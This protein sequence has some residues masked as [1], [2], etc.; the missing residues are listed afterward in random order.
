MQTPSP[1]RADSLCRMD[2]PVNPPIKPM[3]AKPVPKLP[4]GD[5]SYEM[6]WDGFRCIVFRD[7]DEIVLGS[8]NEKPLNRYFP[9]MEPVLMARS[10]R[11]AASSTVS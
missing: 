5:V 9:E 3:L 2:L 6:K 4:E 8:R 7:G 10:C 1:G 11:S